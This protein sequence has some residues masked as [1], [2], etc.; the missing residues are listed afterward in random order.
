MSNP[1]GYAPADS[2]VGSK[3]GNTSGTHMETIYP[4]TEMLHGEAREGRTVVFRI[5]AD[6]NKHLLPRNCRL[7]V[8]Y[9]IG[10]GEVSSTASDPSKG[11][12]D[13]KAAKPS[14]YLRMA[15]FCNSAL[16]DSQVRWVI[17]NITVESIPNFYTH[18]LVQAMLSLNQEGPLSSGSNQLN[19]L[20]KN[21]GLPLSDEPGSQAE[22]DDAAS[23]QHIV[24]GLTYLRQK[25]FAVESGALVEN[26]EDQLITLTKT[27]TLGQLV[28]LIRS[29][30]STVYNGTAG[31]VKPKADVALGA[32]AIK[33]TLDRSV[34]TA[35]A[36]MRNLIGAELMAKG[37]IAKVGE[38]TAY[39]A[40]ELVGRIT[41]AVYDDAAKEVSV[42]ISPATTNEL[43]TTD[44]L[45]LEFQPTASLESLT[46]AE[47]CNTLNS[48]QKSA[49]T[50]LAM[51]NPKHSVLQSTY[52]ESEECSIVE[53]SQPLLLSTWASQY[54]IGPSAMELHM[55]FSPSWRSDIMTST[56][57]AYGCPDG[58]GG[59]VSG[60]L[61]AAANRKAGQIYVDI[62]AIEFH[63]QFVRPVSPYT[64]PSLSW[65]HHPMQLAS[66]QVLDSTV[67][68]VVNVPAST[69]AL[70]CFTRQRI[71][72]ICCDREALGHA[73]G[74]VDVSGQTI[75]GTLRNIQHKGRFE[76]NSIAYRDVIN[77]SSSG[78]RDPRV[79]AYAT[80][81]MSGT[82][83]PDTTPY[84]LT[85]LQVQLA[86]ALSPLE[87]LSQMNPKTGKG[88]AR[89]FDMYSQ[90]IGKSHGYRG[91]VLNFAQYNGVENAIFA[92]GPGAGTDG[93]IFCCE[94][95][96]PV[97]NLSTDAVIRA[98]FAGIPKQAAQQEFVVMAVTDA[99]FQMGWSEGSSTATM[100]ETVPI[101]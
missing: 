14:P 43:K 45:Y 71:N 94:L 12:Q 39:E 30:R 28:S 19:S 44:T 65:K 63:A 25:P 86:S 61:P 49:A 99:L 15:A 7:F 27:D 10:Y 37:A 40:D 95:Q 24:P 81:T 11:P 97:G 41:N 38:G 59:V 52:D 34:S 36:L 16:F 31:D 77:D 55:T 73:G 64:P 4:V 85:Q 75:T 68:T 50:K 88:M 42:T 72:H 62:D 76:Y 2:E 87:P 53:T 80:E 33:F 18:T 89:A 74:S 32:T 100:V 92:S 8:R 3:Y 70:I 67:N 83:V 22:G 78:A 20:A 96:T 90:Y 58:N 35:T 57:G 9:K 82:T 93:P 17:S 47:F 48:V 91:S 79:I 26:D 101:V 84:G 23:R 29:N 51:P 13:G 69:R 54:A 56:D 60:L 21:I 66:F 46:L 98:Q 5:Q 1:F 6:E